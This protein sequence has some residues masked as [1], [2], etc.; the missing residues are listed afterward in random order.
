VYAVPFRLSHLFCFRRLKAGTYSQPT[1]TVSGKHG[2]SAKPIV[3]GSAGDGEV[4]FD[5]T[6]PITT[7]WQ[8][9]E[10]NVYVTTTEAPVWQL[11]ADR[12]MQVSARWPNARWDD[13]TMYEG[14]EHWVSGLLRPKGPNDQS[15]LLSFSVYSFGS[16]L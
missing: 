10:N 6:A 8:K 14:P 4:L 15:L 16:H 12:A 3:I 5:G 7:D 1:I 13:K 2:T 11:F 9:H